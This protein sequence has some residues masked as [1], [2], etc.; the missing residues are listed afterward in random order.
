MR[1]LSASLVCLALISGPAM[2]AELTPTHRVAPEYPADAVRSRTEG[3]VE[4]EFTV[5]AA[6]TVDDVSVLQAKP[7]RVFERA[8]VTAVKKW[9]FAPDQPGRAKVRLD[10][11]L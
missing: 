7:S 8:A 3:F 4:V 11:N 9:S 10:F 6:G 5:N 2:S 1:L